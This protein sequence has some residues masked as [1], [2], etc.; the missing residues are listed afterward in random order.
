MRINTSERRGKGR[1]AVASAPWQ[2]MKGSDTMRNVFPS[3]R[4]PHG[5]GRQSPENGQTPTGATEHMLEQNWNGGREGRSLG[6]R[7]GVWAGRAALGR[8]AFV[9]ST[10]SLLPAFWV[11]AHSLCAQ[12]SGAPPSMPGYGSH[13]FS[14]K[15]VP[16][17]GFPFFLKRTQGYEGQPRPWYERSQRYEDLWLQQGASLL[18]LYPGVYVPNYDCQCENRSPG[19]RAPPI[20]DTHFLSPQQGVSPVNPLLPIIQSSPW[21]GRA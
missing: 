16:S 11:C 4:P 20:L 13:L 2:P 8:R 5:G 1:G 3:A 17:G 15:L 6:S 14:R 19:G 9:P 21:A 18:S 7:R 12:S 10:S